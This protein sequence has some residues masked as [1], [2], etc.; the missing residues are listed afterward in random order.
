MS[1]PSYLPLPKNSAL[2]VASSPV[3]DLC[4]NLC[5]AALTNRLH[6]LEG[7][8]LPLCHLRGGVDAQPILCTVMLVLRIPRLAWALHICLVSAGPIQS[9]VSRPRC[10]DTERLS[11]PPPHAMHSVRCPS[12]LTYHHYRRSSFWRRTP[13]RHEAADAP[14]LVHC[15]AVKQVDGAASYIAKAPH[16]QPCFLSAFHDGSERSFSNLVA[17]FG[18]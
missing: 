16:L 13:R 18:F 6:I 7:I 4:F 12:A 15:P 17:V 14:G 10:S 3:Q 11:A 9:L 2:C 5:Y 1:H 8:A